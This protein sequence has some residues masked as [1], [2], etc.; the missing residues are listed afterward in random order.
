MPSVTLGDM[1]QGFLLRK[2]NVAL[3]AEAQRLATEVATGRAADPARA[4]RGDLVPVSAIET[5]LRRL[6]GYRA[7]TNDADLVATGMQQV[8]GVLDG[9]GDGL[10]TTLLQAG[11]GGQRAMLGIAGVEGEGRLASALAAL[12]TQLGGRS[13]F[14]GEAVQGPATIGSD[15]LLGLLDG[16]VAGAASGDEVADRVAAWFS[17]PA[18]YAALAYVGGAP[19]G[20]LPLSQTASVSLDIT[21]A[22]PAIRAT[23]EGLALAALLARG[24]IPPDEGARVV[25]AA[26]A[27]DTLL[28]AKTPRTDLAAGLGL[29]EARISDARDR[30]D[31]EAAALKLARSALLDVDSYEVSVRL[32]A[33]QTQIETLYAVTARL[34]RLSL[35]DYL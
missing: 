33:T 21:A 12:D 8:L 2:Q 30:N 34:S 29:A 22:D 5:S 31:A 17:D 32:E 7:A 3:Q 28:A 26:R 18:G 11:S 13:L 23:I 25:I 4:V 16:V 10:T 6:D 24:S 14:A 1:A 35:V 15:A 27:A 19:A 9:L 20:D